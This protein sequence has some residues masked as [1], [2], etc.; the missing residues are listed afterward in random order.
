MTKRFLEEP[1]DKNPV[2]PTGAADYQWPGVSQQ[3][4]ATTTIRVAAAPV[5]GT[6][7][8][9]NYQVELDAAWLDLYGWEKPR[10]PEVSGSGGGGATALTVN[11]LGDGSLMVTF[12][13]IPGAQR[14][15]LYFGRL[16]TLPTGSYDHGA[17]A[18][19][20]PLC[21]AP[22]QSA[23][24]GR[25]SITI[26]P[27]SQPGLDTYLLVTAHVDDVESPAGFRSDGTEIDRSQSVCR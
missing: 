18:P 8:N 1:F 20:G 3:D 17:G 21:D 24:P 12:S 10:P 5:A 14:Y 2:L 4:L 16:S 9:D 23:G 25:L 6:A 7:G 11:Q 26:P 22:T 19:A 27:G 15:N 13:A